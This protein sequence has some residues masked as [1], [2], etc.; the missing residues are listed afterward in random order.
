MTMREAIDPLT[1]V[2]ANPSVTVMR[3]VAAYYVET[4]AHNLAQLDALL[5]NKVLVATFPQLLAERS[6][7]EGHLEY[8]RQMAE[9]LEIMHD[10][11]EAL[12]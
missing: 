1:F 3:Q 9:I 4:H 2:D 7:Y 6:W 10:E 11:E 8:W 5:A 12:S